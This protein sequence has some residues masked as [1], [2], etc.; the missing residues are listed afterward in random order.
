M[1][2]IKNSQKENLH[3]LTLCHIACFPTSLA[4]RLGA[5]YVQKTL[6]WFL[7]NPNRFLFH[8]IKDAK[9][10]GYCGGFIPQKPGDGS[11]SGMLQ[12]AFKEAA[13]GVMKNPF[14]LF[15][16]E[17][18]QN[19]RFLWLNIKRRIS[20]KATPIKPV[21][22]TK[23]FAPYVGLVVIGVLP[24]YRG[25]GLAQQLMEEFELRARNFNQ[26]EMVLSVKKDNAR[27][28]KAYA[29]FGWKVK[30]EHSKTFVMHK[31]I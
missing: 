14:L 16:P 9:V 1:S 23:P 29:N 7:V 4:K 22:A 26:N 12:Y 17:V 31:S 21:S 25:Q 2:I 19:Y 15:H 24:G 5:P 11:S 10:V 28:I 27:A 3:D 18:T 30:E 6:E 20:G 8:I 13:R